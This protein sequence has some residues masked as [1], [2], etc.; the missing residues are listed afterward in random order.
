[1]NNFFQELL[2]LIQAILTP[3]CW[4]RNYKYDAH[5]D[6]YLRTKLK[7]GETWEDIGR[8]TARFGGVLLW[9]E[10]YPYASFYKYEG[11]WKEQGGDR[12]LPSRRTTILLRRS[13]MEAAGGTLPKL[14]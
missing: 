12:F 14:D 4:I 2:L 10:N 7:Q 1:M 6:L 13:L 8:Y 3:S 5:W 9:I 11:W